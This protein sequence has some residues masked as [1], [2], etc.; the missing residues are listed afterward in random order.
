ME[1][2]NPLLPL[3]SKIEREIFDLWKE[4]DPAA[5]FT[6]GIKESAGK[7]FIPVDKNIEAM[8]SKIKATLN[9][10]KAVNQRKL[11]ECM[12]MALDFREP[13]HVIS[14]AR[15]A[16]FAHM[17]KEGI[18]PDHMLTLIENTRR[19]IDAS[20][21][22]L[23][24][25]KWATETKIIACQ[26]CD[27]LK[28]LLKTIVT[29]TKDERLKAEL[30]ELIKVVDDYR[31]T[32]LV[33]GLAE[34]DFTEVFPI[35]EK[36]V[37]DL[38]H[39]SVYP[40]ILKYMFDYYE[41]PKQIEDKALRQLKRELPLFRDIIKR[42]A[43]AYGCEPT[44]EEVTKMI[45]RRSEIPKPKIMEYVLNIRK[46]ILKVLSKDLVGITPKYDTRVIET[47]S[48]LVNFIPTAATSAFNMLTDKPF[49][50]FFLTTDEKRSPPAGAADMIQTIVHEETGHC[51]HF[52]N[53]ATAFGG[54][55]SI[56]DLL[57]SYLG[58]AISDAISFH[59]EY[60]FLRLLKNL[61]GKDQDSL[62]PEEKNFLDA[63]RGGR[64][65]SVVLLENEFILMQW[66]QIRFLRAIFDSRVNMG[67]QTVA[68]FVKWGHQITG[69]QEKMIFN[70]TFMF[71]ENV[72]YAP[73]YFI[74]GD[75]LREIQEKA[76]K[77]GVNLVDFN[78]Y[79]TS[80]GYGARTVFEKMLKDYSKRKPNPKTTG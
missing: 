39:R 58:Y 45:I 66:R 65:L 9:K 11:L 61:A 80:I 78:T 24:G 35:I 25:M 4:F 38:G 18:N 36:S 51:V 20:K 62:S 14:N 44:F 30:G 57:D 12:N 10:T 68:E 74:A 73:V 50:I 1:G 79:A 48:Y 42:L 27:E 33:E 41:T 67:K 19:A 3:M 26:S 70:Q 55:P 21:E 52:Q 13:H 15:G 23:R 63:M 54:K 32:F 69:L 16:F 49:S 2:V 53:S 75:A 64:D 5:A 34:G 59:R 29:E 22:K 31:N 43:K 17:V 37:G 6:L 72:G 56:V 7:M 46:N 77:S 40:K 60:E 8:K 76:I 47:P 28:G 71:L